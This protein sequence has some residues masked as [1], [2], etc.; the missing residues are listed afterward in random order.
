MKI[1]F[2]LTKDFITIS[3]N[4]S[5]IDVKASSRI[6]K[7]GIITKSNIDIPKGTVY[8]IYKKIH[9]QD[10]SISLSVSFSI[11]NRIPYSADL[12][13]NSINEARDAGWD[14]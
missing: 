8:S 10:G 2:A 13:Y 14:V 5:P 7:N 9:N 11:E 4:L 3:S 6:Q 1:H 12:T